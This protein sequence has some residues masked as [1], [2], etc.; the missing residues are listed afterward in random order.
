[1]EYID[2]EGYQEMVRDT[3]WQNMDENPEYEASYL[4]AVSTMLDYLSTD[5]IQALLYNHDEK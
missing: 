4:N 2:E 5:E 1:M 3:F